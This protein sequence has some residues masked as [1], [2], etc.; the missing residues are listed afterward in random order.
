M[1]V[2][3]YRIEA[4]IVHPPISDLPEPDY[5]QAEPVE[6]LNGEWV[7]WDDYKALVQGDL[8]RLICALADIG[9][10]ENEGDGWRKRKALR[11]YNEMRQKYP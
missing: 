4:E 6:A 5:A 11:L 3:R 10:N 9:S 7:K 1:T 8:E 2:K